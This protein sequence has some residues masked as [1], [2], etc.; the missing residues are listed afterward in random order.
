MRHIGGFAWGLRLTLAA[1]V[2]LY[3]PNLARAAWHDIDK[4]AALNDTRDKL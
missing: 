1:V 3:A 2:E 4:P